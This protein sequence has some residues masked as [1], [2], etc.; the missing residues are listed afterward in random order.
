MKPLARVLFCVL[1]G[2]A[3]FVASAWS[4]DEGFGTWSGLFLQ[5][6]VAPNWGWFMESQARLNEGYQA[7]D[8]VNPRQLRNNR[9]LLRPAIRYLPRGNGTLQFH[10]GYGWTP[11][12]SPSRDES[13]VYQQ[14]LL[15][16]DG[17]DFW[18]AIR[19]RLEERWIENSSGTALRARLFGRAQWY[20]A[21]EK[22][23]ALATWGEL[24][25]GLNSVDGG[26]KA[27]FD[28]TRLF[29]GPHL[30]VNP[31]TRFEFGYMNNYLDKGRDTVDV[32]NH[33]LVVYT[34]VDL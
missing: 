18:W 25:W 31:Q 28:Q 10:F 32:M 2:L 34:Y 12:F 23:F 16:N 14:A 27:G 17:D 15:Q 3:S 8:P 13:R 33:I 4:A 26:P 5:G 22:F 24:F 29:V 20:L 1:L 30:K 11:N 19:G 7:G 9:Y 21:P 6:A